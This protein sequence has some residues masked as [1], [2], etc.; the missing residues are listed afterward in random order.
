[1]VPEMVA[2]KGGGWEGEEEEEEAEVE[3]RVSRSA[4]RADSA[5]GRVGIMGEAHLTVALVR[6][7]KPALALLL[8]LLTPVLVLVS[9][10]VSKPPSLPPL[11]ES[12]YCPPITPPKPLNNP[13]PPPLVPPPPTPLSARTKARVGGG[14]VGMTTTGEVSRVVLP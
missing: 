3:N 10:F 14:R 6:G 4:Y 9:V 11:K 1:M 2:V 5:L 7:G 13:F 8:L 12:S